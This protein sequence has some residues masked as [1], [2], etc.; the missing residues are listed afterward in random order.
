ME[1]NIIALAKP[2]VA[3]ETKADLLGAI[4]R[5]RIAIESGVVT[6]LFIIPIQADYSYQIIREGDMVKTRMLGL[7]CQAQFDLLRSSESS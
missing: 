5:V 3:E 2:T 6:G 4:E 1:S 7:L